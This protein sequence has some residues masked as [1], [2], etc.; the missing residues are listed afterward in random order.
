MADG[1]RDRSLTLMA[2]NRRGAALVPD[3]SRLRNTP[4]TRSGSAAS[5]GMISHN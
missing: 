1:Y 4:D 3:A 2:A 5:R